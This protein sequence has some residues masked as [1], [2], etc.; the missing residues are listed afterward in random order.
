M[1]LPYRPPI[2]S[3]LSLTG[4]DWVW[5]RSWV[6]GRSFFPTRYSLLFVGCGPGKIR[7]P[8]RIWLW[9]QRLR[10]LIYRHNSVS[11]LME[12]NKT[13]P[14]GHLQQMSLLMCPAHLAAMSSPLRMPLRLLVV[15]IGFSLIPI[16]AL[17][18]LSCMVFTNA[19]RLAALLTQ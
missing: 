13:S 1:R 6:V 10:L 7:M 12:R 4:A 9:A 11:L 15:M 2:L 19:L 5:F 3:G 18:A 17:L 16:S 8:K 14:Q